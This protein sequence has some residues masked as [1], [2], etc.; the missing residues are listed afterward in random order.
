MISHSNTPC[1]CACRCRPSTPDS[2][3]SRAAHHLFFCF[4]FA[5]N[6]A[7]S[8]ERLTSERAKSRATR[9]ATYP[10]AAPG[11]TCQRAA[12]GK[13]CRTPPRQRLSDDAAQ[14][15]TTIAYARR[16]SRV[17]IIHGQSRAAGRHTR[18]TERRGTRRI[19]QRKSHARTHARMRNRREPAVLPRTR[20]RGHPTHSITTPHAPTNSR[21]RM[22]TYITYLRM[23][24]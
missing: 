6:R 14:T 22:H 10:T 7:P 15:P 11:G 1:A 19:G 16:T 21:I 9:R 2:L 24:A 4:V 17:V 3:R 5:Q 8:R 13:S 12:R 18:G 20:R 23:R